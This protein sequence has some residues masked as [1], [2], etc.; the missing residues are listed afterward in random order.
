MYCGGGT[1]NKIV[2]WGRW[3]CIY[4]LWVKI[5]CIVGEGHMH[6]VKFIPGGDNILFEGS[7]SLS[8]YLGHSVRTDRFSQGPT[9]LPAFCWTT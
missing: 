8:E 1:S 5:I 7:S 2:L 3:S 4:V 6:D 9:S